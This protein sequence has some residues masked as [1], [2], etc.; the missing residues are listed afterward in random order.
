MAE[1]ILPNVW[2]K[3]PPYP[4]PIDWSNPSSAGL[5]VA[6][7]FSQGVSP[8]EI[9]NRVLLTPGSTPATK[10]DSS[11]GRGRHFNNA[12]T[13]IDRA[14]GTVPIPAAST[15]Q[16]YTWLVLVR[17]T[18]TNSGDFFFSFGDSAGGTNY[19][20]LRGAG[21]TT[22]IQIGWGA[23]I[24]ETYSGVPN[25]AD[26]NYHAIAVTAPPIVSPY[27][28]GVFIDG[29]RVATKTT[30]IAAFSGYTYLGLGGLNRNSAELPTACDIA[31][32]WMW[33]RA[34][35]DVEIADL[36]VNPWQIFQAPARR[37]WASTASGGDVTVSITGQA[38][39]TAQGT[40]SP[41]TAVSATGQAST[42][43]QGS[44]TQGTNISGQAA[45]AAQ[46]TVTPSIDVTLAGQALTTAQGAVTPVV[47]VT[48]T[49]QSAAM[50]QG[51]VTP[52]VDVSLTG[53]AATTQQGSVSIA[54]GN[55]VVSITGQSISAS[56]GTV[57]VTGGNAKH[58]GDDVPWHKSP[59]Q[60]YKRKSRNPLDLITVDWPDEVTEETR[61][62]VVDVAAKVVE[63]REFDYKPD[64]KKLVRSLE[65]SEKTL[66]LKLYEQMLQ[67]QITRLE[68]EREEEEMLIML[69]DAA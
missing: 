41:A 69:L 20:G 19:G 27:N 35:S 48:L 2:A 34:L 61:Q 57:G 15:T 28:N 62:Q 11:T 5:M 58:G 25:W 14:M 56:Q 12:T 22:S 39:T 31:G 21:A 23:A 50:Q 1:L 29:Y 68:I 43:A 33:Q 30:N 32:V 60:G 38:A 36:S 66:G 67:A 7:D 3:Q 13:S 10:I 24:N 42:S 53:Q 17:T 52:A 9:I 40:V 8:Y 54:G 26:G 55:V 59:H 46:G 65:A 45:T 51:T 4:A 44:V 63:A 6:L 49:G 37:L 18:E 47:N 16:G 64:L